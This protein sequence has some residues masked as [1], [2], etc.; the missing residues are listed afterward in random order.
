MNN[1]TQEIVSI[2]FLIFVLAIAMT[3]CTDCAEA[4]QNLTLTEAH[5]TWLEYWEQQGTILD[6]RTQEEYD[7]GHIKNAILIPH[8]QLYTLCEPCKP[9]IVKVPNE[10]LP[11]N[12]STPILVYCKAGYRST[13]AARTL[14]ELGYTDV[15]NMVDGLDKWKEAGY[16][17]ETTTKGGENKMVAWTDIMAWIERLAIVAVTLSGLWLIS[18]VA[19]QKDKVD[20]IMGAALLF[21]CANI[22]WIA[23]ILWLMLRT[24]VP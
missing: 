16:E 19:I 2:F 3:I 24:G 14:E 17:Y 20:E 1:Q 6:V 8:D 22:F 5:D 12:N 9:K 10:K 7:T 11:E 4:Y 18:K 15:S 13:L 21:I 23:T